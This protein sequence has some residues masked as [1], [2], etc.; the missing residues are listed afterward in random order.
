MFSEG[1]EDNPEESYR[2]GQRE[3]EWMHAIVFAVDVDEHD[4]EN[5]TQ[6]V[7]Q[8]A[9][10]RGAIMPRLGGTKVQARE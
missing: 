4:V 5:E 10:K 3:R 2:G 6:E 1:Y 7:L 8:Y 9:I